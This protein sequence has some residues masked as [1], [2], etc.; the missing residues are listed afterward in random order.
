[1]PSRLRLAVV[2]NEAAGSLV[3]SGGDALRQTIAVAFERQGI[4]A[5]LNFVKSEKLREAAEQALKQV[6]EG[7]FDA[8]AVGGG[9]GSIRTFASVLADTGV[10]VGLL[11]LG[12]LNHF[13]RDVGAPR[14]IEAAVALIAA[15]QTRLVDLGEANGRVFINN[16][17]IG[18]YPYLVVE[19]E[20]R[21]RRQGLSK[22]TAMS[23][24][25]L[26]ALWR[27]PLRRLVVHAGESSERC[28]S[29]CVFIGNNSYDLAIPN[30]GARKSLD[31]GELSVY[32]AKSQSWFA[33]AI[34]ACRALIGLLNDVRDFRIVKGPSAEIGSRTSRLLVAFDGEVELLAQPLR[35]RIR[36]GALRVYAPPAPAP[37][38]G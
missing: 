10:A 37:N 31:R 8:I 1:M 25:A 32:I 28:R 22:W 20:R 26:R 34:I 19:R 11:P 2:L 7:E 33:L 27:L 17:S 35:Y 23:L 4:A 14:E 12:T 5:D 29:P 15:G 38:S 18:V 6:K 36:P 30:V 13:A 24:S 9:D 3:G 21:R 16:S